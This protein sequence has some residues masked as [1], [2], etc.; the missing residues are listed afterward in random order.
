MNV[1]KIRAL[2]DFLERLHELGEQFDMNTWI[3]TQTAFYEGHCGTSACIAGWCAI[4][5]IGQEKALKADWH[6]ETRHIAAAALGI[7]EWTATHLFTPRGN[8]P[9]SLAFIQLDYNGRDPWR[10]T[11]LEAARVLRHLADT[12]ELDWS[13]ALAEGDRVA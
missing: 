1:E 6:G 12:G 10:C 5:E 13:A 2:A 8:S 11:E 4:M 9:G 3:D 7:D